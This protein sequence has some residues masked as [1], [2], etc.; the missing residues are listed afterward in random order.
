ML[1]CWAHDPYLDDWIL[2]KIDAMVA[3]T[4]HET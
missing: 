3:E 4:G 1:S 2:M